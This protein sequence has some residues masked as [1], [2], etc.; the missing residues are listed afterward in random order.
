MVA[1]YLLTETA[2]NLKLTNPEIAQELLT[3]IREYWDEY[4]PGKL[5]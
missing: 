2:D 1:E 4:E 3:N 5:P